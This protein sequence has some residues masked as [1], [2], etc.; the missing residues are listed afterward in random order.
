MQNLLRRS[1]LR[2]SARGLS[3]AFIKE[4][5]ATLVSLYTKRITADSTVEWKEIGRTEIISASRNPDYQIAFELDHYIGHET[6]L[7]FAVMSLPVNHTRSSRREIEVGCL[8]IESYEI[9]QLNGS[10]TR[11]LT[12]PNSTKTKQGI[13]RICA[14]EAIPHSGTIVKMQFQA[15]GL[16]RKEL[17]RKN[18]VFYTISRI[19]VDSSYMLVYRSDALQKTLD[20]VWPLIEIDKSTLC[21]EQNDRDI[22]IEVHH[23]RKDKTSELI[24]SCSTTFYEIVNKRGDLYFELVNDKGIKRLHT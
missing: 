1:E 16:E 12:L 6:T 2:V 10:I 13:L 19:Q 8:E 15:S 5:P 21:G 9:S 7:K 11:S 3:D 14:E 23:A 22:K 18:D 17:M 24:G 4:L 20:P